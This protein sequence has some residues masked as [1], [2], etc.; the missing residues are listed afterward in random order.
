[1]CL[2]TI[3]IGDNHANAFCT[4]FATPNL[5][6]LYVSPTFVTVPPLLPYPWYTMYFS[7]SALQMS[8]RLQ[9][10]RMKSKI[11]LGWQ[12]KKCWSAF[13]FMHGISVLNMYRSQGSPTSW[14][15]LVKTFTIAL[16]QVSLFPSIVPLELANSFFHIFSKL[17]GSADANRP[18]PSNCTRRLILTFSTVSRKYFPLH[19]T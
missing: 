11:G 4:I 15:A 10:G 1:M 13:N 7:K 12:G 5:C 16:I 17:A 2:K 6:H 18:R 14:T 19:Y 3:R 8:L 9:D